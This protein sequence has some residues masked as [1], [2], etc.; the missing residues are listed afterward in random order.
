MEKVG[1]VKEGVLRLNRVE[2]GEAF[3]EAWF[4]ILRREWQELMDR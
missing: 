4:A 2:R 1:M 3:D